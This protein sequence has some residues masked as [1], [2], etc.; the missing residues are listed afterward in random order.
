LEHL[1][2]FEVIKETTG[3][4]KESLTLKEKK[5][6]GQIYQI[7][8]YNLLREESEGYSKLLIDLLS[9]TSLEFF[10]IQSLIAQFD[11]EPN[12][13][14]DIT[15]DCFEQRMDQKESFL[16]LIQNFNTNNIT[17]LVGFKFLYYSK[18]K[19]EIPKSLFQLTSILIQNELIS[20]ESIY[21]YVMKKLIELQVVHR[22]VERGFNGSKVSIN[23]FSF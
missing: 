20:I 12:R 21:E 2:D 10:K 22:R 16:K 7:L 4:T 17:I 1:E 19:K 15:L 8:K 9:S 3:I 18:N 6:R 11:L 23:Y 13:V 5:Q 14:L